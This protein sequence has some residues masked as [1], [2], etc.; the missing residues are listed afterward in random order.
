MERADGKDFG[1]LWVGLWIEGDMWIKSEYV[2]FPG[3]CAVDSALSRCLHSDSRY[4]LMIAR[5]T[6]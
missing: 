5:L 6:R 1:G 4:R 2:R 3:D